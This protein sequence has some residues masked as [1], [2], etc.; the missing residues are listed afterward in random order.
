[1]DL[2][3]EQQG[4]NSV[5]QFFQGRSPFPVSAPQLSSVF[6]RQAHFYKALIGDIISV[7]LPSDD[8]QQRQ[9]IRREMVS[10]ENFN[11]GIDTLTVPAKSKWSV[12]SAIFLQDLL[13]LIERIVFHFSFFI[14]C[15]SSRPRE[16]S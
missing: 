11:F 15:T 16:L 2:R 7:R 12:R 3:L 5:F 1:M 8:I 13:F 4:C 10:V 6:F 9:C 14:G